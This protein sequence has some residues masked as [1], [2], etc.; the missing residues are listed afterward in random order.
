[1]NHGYVQNTTHY[2]NESLATGP[3][4]NRLLTSPC[5]NGSVS[6]GSTVSPNQLSNHTSPDAYSQYPPQWREQ[7]NGECVQ[8][9]YN[10]MLDQTR[11]LTWC[12]NL[13]LSNR[14]T[15]PYQCCFQ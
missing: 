3:C 12:Q 14:K 8:H 1:M 13:R 15:L 10:Y 11:L 4:D 7:V 6:S 5:G 2:N 9:E